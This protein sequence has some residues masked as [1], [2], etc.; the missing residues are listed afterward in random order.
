MCADNPTLSQFIG[1]VVAVINEDLAPEER[2][3][4]REICDAIEA[5]GLT[6]TAL[7]QLV[8]YIAGEEI[9]Y[10]PQ[11]ETSLFEYLDNLASAIRVDQ[12]AQ[13]V[14]EQ[15]N[16]TIADLVEVFLNS[17]KNQTLGEA[18]NT[19]FDVDVSTINA[20]VEEM[21][22]NASLKT[23]SQSRLTSLSLEYAIDCSM[24]EGETQFALASSANL[25]LTI[26]Y[27]KFTTEMVIPQ[28]VLNA[29]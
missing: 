12:L 23:D 7:C 3:N 4:L 1:R 22:A 8:N 6:V 24:Q 10:E 27:D 28:K 5:E 26:S 9:L 19:L 29:I 14:L 16:A 2:I 20:V 13:M 17:I 18:I 21:W 15:D 11:E 25:A